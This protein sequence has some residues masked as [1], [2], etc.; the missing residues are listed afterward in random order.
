[1][2]FMKPK[3][4]PVPE[5]PPP[6]VTESDISADDEAT[7]YQKKRARGFNYS[8]TLLSDKSSEGNSE[9]KSILG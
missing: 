4:P 8:K 6:V 9:K 5:A 2:G 7:V 1:M 3:A